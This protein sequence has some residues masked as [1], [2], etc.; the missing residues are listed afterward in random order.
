MLVI[1]DLP[2]FRAAVKRMLEAFGA[3]EVD[4]IASG[5]DAL[6]NLEQKTYDIIVCDYNLGDGKDGQQ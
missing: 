2:D 6:S 1:D 4:V 3:S 5:D